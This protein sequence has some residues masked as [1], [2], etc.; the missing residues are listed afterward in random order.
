MDIRWR[1]RM[2]RMENIENS[3]VTCRRIALP[4]R[5]VAATPAAIM[6]ADACQK[7]SSPN[8]LEN[9]FNK[10]SGSL[11]Y[12]ARTKL[13]GLLAERRLSDLAMIMLFA[14]ELPKVDHLL[15]KMDTLATLF[16]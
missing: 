16:P 2:E 5:A 14:F 10:P 1:R 9:Q 4:A 15:Q 7:L 6:N 13:N 8:L 11:G 3:V 12:Q